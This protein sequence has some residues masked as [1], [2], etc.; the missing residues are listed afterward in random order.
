MPRNPSIR[1]RLE[2]EAWN[3]FP[4]TA[5]RIAGRR[6]AR[7]DKRTLSFYHTHTAD[8]LEVTYFADGRYLPGSMEQLRDFLA[9]WRNGHEHDI[10]PGLMDILWE[11]QQATGHEGTWEVISSYRSPVALSYFS[12]R[13]ARRSPTSIRCSVTTRS[14]IGLSQSSSSGGGYTWIRPFRSSPFGKRSDL[15]VR[16]SNR[17]TQWLPILPYPWCEM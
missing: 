12:T 6:A 16:R 9:D 5:R 2:A 11:I 8:T 1:D 4:E 13:P 14:V 7:R 3:H 17:W 15:P 10:D